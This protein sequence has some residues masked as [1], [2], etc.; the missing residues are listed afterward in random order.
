[1]Y[2]FRTNRLIEDFQNDDV[3]QKETLKYLV[4][5]WL[6]FVAVNLFFE[7]FLNFSGKP[8]SQLTPKAVFIKY[9]IIAIINIGGIYYCYRKNYQGNETRFV[10]RFVCLSIPVGFKVMFYCIVV[11]IL[12]SILAVVI[13]KEIYSYLFGSGAFDFS[14]EII[15]VFVFF[16]YMGD[17]FNK[18]STGIARKNE[19]NAEVI[20]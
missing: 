16:Y 11:I 17:C 7:M 12:Q 6:G 13:K 1:M 19:I 5:L 18:I 20:D 14:L 15:F 3:S 10:E 9:A 8:L 2:L 4:V